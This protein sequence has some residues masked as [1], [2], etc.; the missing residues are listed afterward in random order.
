MEHLLT[1]KRRLHWPV[2]LARSDRRQNRVGIDP[3][4][5]TK[6]AADVRADQPDVLDWNVEGPGDRVAPLTQH[7][8]G[9]MKNEAVAVPHGQ[10]CVGLHHGLALQRRGVRHVELDGSRSESAG[11]IT[12]GAIRRSETLR[13]ARLIE[14]AAQ[15]KSTRQAL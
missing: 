15:S 12:H 10:C 1:C 3:K 7:L 5:G 6:P 9:G 8:V 13:G 11:E 14:A 2:E 4:L